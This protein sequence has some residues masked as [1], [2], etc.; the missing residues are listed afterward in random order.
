MHRIASDERLVA[1]VISSLQTCKEF[2]RFVMHCPPKRCTALHS[3]V[4]RGNASGDAGTSSPS[5]LQ[6]RSW[7]SPASPG[8]AGLGIVAQS[9]GRIT[10]RSVIRSF[11]YIPPHYMLRS[12]A[13][14]SQATCGAALDG[15]PRRHPSSS[16]HRRVY[17]VCFRI[18]GG[19]HM[20][21]NVCKIIYTCCTQR[22]HAL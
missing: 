19:E 8:S 7:H 11:R 16:F 21:D 17:R 22:S 10:S 15:S 9:T 1:L 5:L 14:R 3:A 12:D 4:T 13:L 18:R 20:I 2:H 6:E